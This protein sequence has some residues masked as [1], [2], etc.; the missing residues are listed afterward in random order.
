M[1]VANDFVACESISV[2]QVYIAHNVL[3]TLYG[4]LVYES[5]YDWHGC[6]N[7]GDTASG[8]HVTSHHITNNMMT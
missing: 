7:G 6:A 5:E 8:Y 1:D 4:V 2:V 3:T